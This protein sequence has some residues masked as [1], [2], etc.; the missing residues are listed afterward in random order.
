MVNVL[1][2][3][4]V[5]LD[6]LLLRKPFY[7]TSFELSLLQYFDETLYLNIS[8]GSIPNLIYFVKEKHKVPEANERLIKWI[9][10]CDVISSTKQ[11]IL[12]ALKSPFK[13]K[14]D[15]YQYFTALQNDMDYFITRNKKDYEPYVSA[16][17]VY[18]PSEFLA[19]YKS[20]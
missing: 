11:V 16:I 17:P 7:K 10:N 20:Q 3:T 8:E 5:C 1:L 9:S 12:N 19:A 18:T 13:D 4:D 6:I 2:D 14:E 15:A